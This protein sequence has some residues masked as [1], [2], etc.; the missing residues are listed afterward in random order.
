[1]PMAKCVIQVI[2]TFLV[3]LNIGNAIVCVKELLTIDFYVNKK[4]FY[5]AVR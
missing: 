4:I 2:R 1:M 3:P 5:R